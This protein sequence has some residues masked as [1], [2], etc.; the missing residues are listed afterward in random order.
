MQR[1]VVLLLIAIICAGAVGRAEDVEA[2]GLPSIS[3]IDYGAKGDGTTDDSDAVLRAVDALPPSG[4]VVLFP[5]GPYLLRKPI[6]TNARPAIVFRGEGM[7]ESTL[8]SASSRL[9]LG[10]DLGRPRAASLA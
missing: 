4:G 8:P 1:A 10:A 5:H 3:V 9:C 2:D 6:P 7:K